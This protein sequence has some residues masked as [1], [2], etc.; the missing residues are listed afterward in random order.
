MFWHAGSIENTESDI[1]AIPIYSVKHFIMNLWCNC[2][3]EKANKLT[4]KEFVI[5][6]MIR[7][8]SRGK[9]V[10]AVFNHLPFKYF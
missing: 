10:A 3:L 7:R 2:F 5:V 8:A 6:K 4:F 9:V 1:T